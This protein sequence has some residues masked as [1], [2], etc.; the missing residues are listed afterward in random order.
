L[1]THEAGKLKAANAALDEATQ[2]LAAMIVE[3]AMA[4]KARVKR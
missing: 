4:S 3:T 1:E 2:T